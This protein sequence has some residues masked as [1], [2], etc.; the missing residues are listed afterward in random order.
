MYD[1]NNEGDA[2]EKEFPVYYGDI[3]TLKYEDYHYLMIRGTDEA[4]L[5]E[6]IHESWYNSRI[7]MRKM[8]WYK[9]GVIASL[10][11]IAFAFLSFGAHCL[12]YK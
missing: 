12:M 8:K 10:V 7:C 4:F 11:A 1:D 5:E 2:S 3:S 6:L 9:A